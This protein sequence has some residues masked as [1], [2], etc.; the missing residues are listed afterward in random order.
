MLFI[1][2]YRARDNAY[3]TGIYGD[4]SR[5]S[6]VSHYLLLLRFARHL[7]VSENGDREHLSRSGNS[8]SISLAYGDRRFMKD[9]NKR[10]GAMPSRNIDVY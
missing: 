9:Q 10:R 5:D 2:R 7:C 8:F 4:S 6:E 3:A 1:L